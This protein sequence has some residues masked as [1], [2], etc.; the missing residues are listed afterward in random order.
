MNRKFAL[1]FRIWWYALMLKDVA[2]VG[3]AI[4]LSAVPIYL[5]WHYFGPNF[6]PLWDIW[7]PYFTGER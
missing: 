2:L 1:R 3:V 7:H 5:L 4:V 6:G